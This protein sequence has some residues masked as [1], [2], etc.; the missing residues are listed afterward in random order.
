MA[1]EREVLPSANK[2]PKWKTNKTFSE[3]VCNQAN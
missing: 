2:V 1:R 3:F